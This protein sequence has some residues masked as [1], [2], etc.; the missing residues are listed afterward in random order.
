MP[1]TK[2]FSTIA[3]VLIIVGLVGALLAYTTYGAGEDVQQTET[4]EHQS[5]TEVVIES[6]SASINVFPT[7]D[8][9]ITVTFSAKDTRSRQYDFNVQENEETLNI[10]LKEK[11]KFQF[12]NFGFNFTSPEITVYLPEK[13]YERLQ[14]DNVNGKTTVENMSTNEL[15]AT[16]VNGRIDINNMTTQNTIVSSQNGKINLNAVNGEIVGNVV[17]GS[18]TLETDD[19]NQ[20]IDL[21]SVNGKLSIETNEEPT[22]AT[23][24]VDVVNGKIDIFGEKNRNT[25]FGEGDYL[26]QLKTVNGRVSVSK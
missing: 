18:I 8:E 7:N 15:N 12:I 16:T 25:T 21:E 20:F 17:N 23:I 19:L 14:V 5:I 26:I 3:T 2:L 9:L 4:F 1:R 6:D 22:N 10:Q 11:K 13:Q 24:E